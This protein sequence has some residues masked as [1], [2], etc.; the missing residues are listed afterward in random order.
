MATSTFMVGRAAVGAS[1]PAVAAAP[2]HRIPK[3]RG[4]RSKAPSAPRVDFDDLVRE[5]RFE[6]LVRD[7]QRRVTH[8]VYRKCGNWADA[9]EAV[10][11]ALLV[12]WGKRQQLDDVEDPAGWLVTE[13]K[14]SLYRIRK[15]RAKQ[16]PA[17]L[18]EHIERVEDQQ[19]DEPGDGPC[20]GESE[21]MERVRRALATLPPDR[22]RVVEMLCV[23][24]MTTDEVAERT[25]KTHDA[26]YRLLC[27][28]FRDADWSG[29]EWRERWVSDPEADLL[30][31]SVPLLAK[32]PGRV[33]EA[34]WLRYVDGLPV[35]KVAERMRISLLG[36]KTL[37]TRARSVARAELAERAA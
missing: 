19:A 37:L 22:R 30:R 14:W 31:T 34:A 8:M 26:V 27:A 6:M 16:C 18:G 13:A 25:G 7:H 20:L 4:R 35:G 24:G 17:L 9:Q 5:Q 21:T 33:R 28:A 29:P 12:L 10:Q 3:Q 15:D 1:A 36:A 2:T 32:L 11:D 23:Q